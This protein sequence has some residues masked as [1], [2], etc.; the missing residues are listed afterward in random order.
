MRPHRQLPRT[1]RVSGLLRFGPALLAYYRGIEVVPARTNGSGFFAPCDCRGHLQ[2]GRLE[3]HR[4]SVEPLPLK[5]VQFCVA[6]YFLSDG[7]S[8]IFR[9]YPGQL[10]DLG[11]QRL[12]RPH[13]NVRLQGAEA[14][15]PSCALRSRRA[16]DA[17]SRDELRTGVE[18][19]AHHRSGAP[20]AH[21]RQPSGS[22][23]PAI[24]LGK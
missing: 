20:Q 8:R 18:P 7:W 3:I 5:D 11:D 12:H 1:V 16:V 22:R 2:L 10:E 21:S 9:Q 15:S 24:R 19:P 4:V 17:C 14:W 13:R 23:E 6:A